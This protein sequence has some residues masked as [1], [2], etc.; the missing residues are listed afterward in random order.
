[1]SSLN[2]H[3]SAQL[4]SPDIEQAPTRDGFGKGAVEAGQNDE[5]VIVL[6][7]DLT[8]STRAE[9]FQKAFPAGAKAPLIGFS[10]GS[11]QTWH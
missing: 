1:M 11:T 10:Q 8:E 9:W 7:A 4:F 2:P 6:C 5:R 3:L